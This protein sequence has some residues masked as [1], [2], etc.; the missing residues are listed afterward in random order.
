M[1]RIIQPGTFTTVQDLRRVGFQSSGVP[2][3][4]AV[5]KFS[6]RCANLLVGND[7]SD[8][9]LEMTIFGPQITFEDSAVVAVTGAN[10]T[11]LLNGEPCLLYTSPSQ[12][13]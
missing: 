6:M 7:D 9:V 13:D 12:R 8:P 2:E 4:G 1:I 5:D 3:C 11:P 10:L